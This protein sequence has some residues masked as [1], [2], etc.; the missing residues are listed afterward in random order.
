[1]TPPRLTGLITTLAWVALG[2][3]A[4]TVLAGGIL[5]FPIAESSARAFPEFAHLQAPLLVAAVAFVV[6]IEAML[7]TTAM[8]VGCIRNDSIF[9]ATALR[10]VDVLAGLLIVA[11]VILAAVIPSLPG[12]PLLTLVSLASVLAGAT[13]VLVLL[14]LRSLLRRAVSMRFE[15]DEVV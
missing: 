15:L 10:L 12:P 4:L 8:L 14:V 13:F 7:G 5:L 1:M 9:G 11:T 6:C 3:L 2:L